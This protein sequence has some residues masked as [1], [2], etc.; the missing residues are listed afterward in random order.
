MPRM[1]VRSS[2]GAAPPSS[3]LV[4]APDP[5]ATETR[6]IGCDA[7]GARS[8]LSRSRRNSG[9]RRSSGSWSGA[10]TG[11]VG[12]GAAEGAAAAC[13]VVL[14][15]SARSK[16][17]PSAAGRAATSI[18]GWVASGAGAVAG[19]SSG[20][21]VSRR[22][23]DGRPIVEAALQAAGQD[24]AQEERPH[25]PQY[26]LPKQLVHTSPL[27]NNTRARPFTPAWRT[28]STT[29]RTRRRRPQSR[30]GRCLRS[31]SPLAAPPTRAIGCFIHS[32]DNGRL[33]QPT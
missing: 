18:L 27:L 32:F 10:E 24:C 29:R 6:G 17:T 9:G 31:R 14:P 22:L 28:Q 15:A 26:R 2:L 7:A 21:E 1:R 23:A 4:G 19:S 5:V 12:W 25:Q 13:A 8:R 11:A 3:G 20:C 33:E 30:S 16:R